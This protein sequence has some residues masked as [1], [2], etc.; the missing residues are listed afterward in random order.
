[1]RSTFEVEMSDD[2]HTEGVTLLAE[3]VKLVSETGKD[4]FVK[5]TQL[6][7]QASVKRLVTSKSRESWLVIVQ[8]AK[9]LARWSISVSIWEVADLSA[10][11]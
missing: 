11:G 10:L 7:E 2:K 3:H 1:M 5:F 9:R 4:K 6:L 8:L